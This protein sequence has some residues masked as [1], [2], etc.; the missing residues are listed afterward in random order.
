LFRTG[1]WIFP[2]DDRVAFVFAGLA[3]LVGYAKP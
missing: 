1:K 2:A 3:R